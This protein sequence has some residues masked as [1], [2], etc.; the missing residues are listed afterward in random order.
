MHSPCG[1]HPAEALKRRT[2][3]FATEIVKLCR[4]L[5][6]KVSPRTR[7]QLEAS[8]TAIGANHRAACRAKSH[9]DFTAKIATAVEE[10]D[11]TAY[12]LDV[13]IETESADGELLKRLR[14]EA[15]ELLAILVASH[16]TARA[17]QQARR[18]QRRPL[19]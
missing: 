2:Q 7:D 9:D 5:P 12:W 15:G 1:M 18:A 6:G 10:A 13:L 11:E 14:A 8:G 17:N 3:T 16:K 4:T 19:K